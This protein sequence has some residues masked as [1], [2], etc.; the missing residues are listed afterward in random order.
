MF[1]PSQLCWKAS[2][3]Q[4]MESGTGDTFQDSFTFALA[5]ETDERTTELLTHVLEHL[6]KKR[7]FKQEAPGPDG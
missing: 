5:N 6:G 7:A 3:F 4:A 2:A 1:R